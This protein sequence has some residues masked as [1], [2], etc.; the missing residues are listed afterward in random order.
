MPQAALDDVDARIQHTGAWVCAARKDERAQE[1]R[2]R[3]L[4]IH[5]DLT[6]NDGRLVGWL[7]GWLDGWLVGWMVGWMVGWLVG[8]LVRSFVR[9]FVRSLV[10][11]LG[12]WWLLFIGLKGARAVIGKCTN[13]KTLGLS[14]MLALYLFLGIISTIHLQRG[15]PHQVTTNL[16]HRLLGISPSSC[17][18]KILAV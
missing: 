5:E 4:A 6:I 7:V 10:G 15:S 12:D 18:C 1:H 2:T 13:S 11:W 9:S 16:A 3:K 17:C 8:W 14:I